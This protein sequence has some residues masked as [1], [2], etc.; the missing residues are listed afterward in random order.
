MGQW[1]HFPWIAIFDIDITTS[2]QR[3]FYPVYLF[4][5]DMRGGVY[6]SLNQGWTY[7]KGEIWNEVEELKIFHISF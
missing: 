6:L 3:G 1:T 2:A 4:T 5:E 7:F